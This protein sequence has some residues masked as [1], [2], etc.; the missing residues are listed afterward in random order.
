MPRKPKCPCGSRKV[1]PHGRLPFHYFCH[2]CRGSFVPGQTEM[3]EGGTYSNDPTRR[4]QQIESGDFDSGQ[5]IRAYR[6]GL[7]GGL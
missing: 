5:P 3:P 7:R 2:E 4:M 6:P 1:T